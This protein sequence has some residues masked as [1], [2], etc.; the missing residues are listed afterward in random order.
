MTYAELFAEVVQIVSETLAINPAE[1]T[2]STPIYDHAYLDD[3][4]MDFAIMDLEEQLTININDVD[5]MKCIT[6]GE[7]VRYIATLKGVE[8]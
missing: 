6:F 1:L 3:L 8:V 5:A 2:D 4:A 7:F